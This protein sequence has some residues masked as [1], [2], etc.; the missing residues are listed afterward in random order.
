MVKH[1][2]VIPNQHFRKDWAKF[3]KTWFNQP[4]NKQRRRQARQKKAQRVSPRPLNALRPTVRCMTNKYNMRI[5]SGRGFTLEEL[6]AAG[7]NRLAARGVG[8]SVDHRRKNKSEEAF[9]QNVQRL[10]LY[11]SKLVVFPRKPTSKR[12]KKGDASKDERKEV[13]QL[14]AD[15]VMPIVENV[16]RIKARKLTAEEKDSKTFVTRRLR[17]ERTDAKL[18]GIREKRAKDKAEKA[19]LGKK[20]EEKDAKTFVTRRLR[21]ERTDAKLWGIREKRAKDKAEKAKQGKK[22]EEKEAG[23]DE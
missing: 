8:I 20:K 9:Q 3:V 21:K 23:G 2:N 4:A 19:K 7:I 22:K 15:K 14:L 16:P 10:K 1:N 12:L 11:K 18:W 5:R 17:K 13:Q 6:E